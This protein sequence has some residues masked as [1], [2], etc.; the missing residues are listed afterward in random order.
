MC[1]TYHHPAKKDIAEVS[2]VCE[3]AGCINFWAVIEIQHS[4]RS[5]S[6]DWVM[7]SIQQL[8]DSDL[9]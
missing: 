6:R 1:E 8:L 4:I 2:T 7:F 9:L 3:V 5:C